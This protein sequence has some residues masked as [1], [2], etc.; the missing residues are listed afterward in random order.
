MSF[1]ICFW[2]P[3]ESLYFLPLQDALLPIRAATVQLAP[4]ASPMVT[5]VGLWRP[6]LLGPDPWGS[7]VGM[8]GKTHAGAP[9]GDVRL[10]YH[11]TEY[12]AARGPRCHTALN[13]TQGL[14][15]SAKRSARQPSPCPVQSH[16][17]WHS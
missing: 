2:F 12:C 9:G 5:R 4:A 1:F 17:Q 15:P 10:H 6:P 13:G 16:A 14:L 7:G 3:H 8:A 11:H